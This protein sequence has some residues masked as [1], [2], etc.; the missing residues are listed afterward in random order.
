MLTLFVFDE[1]ES[2]REELRLARQRG[3]PQPIRS[4]ADD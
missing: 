3:D 4:N 2:R 1:R